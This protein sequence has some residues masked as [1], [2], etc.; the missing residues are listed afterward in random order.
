MNLPSPL[1]SPVTPASRRCLHQPAPK[2]VR[3]EADGYD[4]PR[5]DPARGECEMSLLHLLDLRRRY[6]DEATRMRES[7]HALQSQLEEASREV[8]HHLA[9]GHVAP[10]ALRVR[11]DD[12]VAA[13]E[14]AERDLADAH[15]A[16]EGI[17]QEVMA[18]VALRQ[19]R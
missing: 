9:L 10:T 3:R 2:L 1:R 15:L 12:L 4:Q 11:C 14:G 7:L 6:R 16:I 19:A 8:W 18:V 5:T 17:G 13:V